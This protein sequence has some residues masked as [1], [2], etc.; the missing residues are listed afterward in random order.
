MRRL[1]IVVLSSVLALW[2]HHSLRYS[3]ADANK[4]SGGEEFQ[5]NPRTRQ[6]NEGSANAKE[7][8]NLDLPTLKT[9]SQTVSPGVLQKNWPGTITNTPASS[10]K[11]IEKLAV[12]NSKNS[13]TEYSDSNGL[14]ETSWQMIDPKNAK[15]AVHALYQAILWRDPDRSG[16]AA[17]VDALSRIGW[18]T[19]IGNAGDMI[20]SKEFLEQIAPNRSAQT[21][22]N[23][24]YAIF[25]NRCANPHEM[26]DHLGNLRDEETEKITSSILNKAIED[27][28]QKIFEGGYNP[29]SCSPSGSM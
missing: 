8:P 13:A 20:K 11:D 3:S 17:A 18:K 6:S 22:I 29:E 24:M 12:Q 28:K 7:Q 23:R 25:L 2:L 21:V 5:T 16:G 26:Q 1:G 19:Y 15:G 10:N 4:N 14:S 27:N 9:R